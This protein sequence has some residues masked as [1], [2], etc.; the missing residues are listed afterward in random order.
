MPKEEPNRGSV[1][2][3]W[4]FYAVRYAMGTVVG[5]VTFSFL[6]FQ[7]SETQ[8]LLFGIFDTAAAGDTTNGAASHSIS[9]DASRLTLLAVYGLVYCY[10]ASA[11]I[12]V[13]HASRFLIRPGAEW[14]AILKWLGICSIFPILFGVLAFC[15]GAQGK[16]FTCTA[17][18]FG[19]L[20][21]LQIV[22]VSLSLYRN[23]ALFDFYKQLAERRGQAKG[24]IVD[25]Y[26]HLREHGNSFFIVFLE[27]A[28]GIVLFEASRLTPQNT[29]RSVSLPGIVKTYLTVLVVWIFPAVFVWLISIFFERRFADAKV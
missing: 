12:L 23:A 18:A 16:W 28:L 15:Y 7:R 26:R 17:S 11:P 21:G 25:S 19:L 3:W 20:L 2:R 27:I 14:K 8:P 4:E 29:D 10:I 13:F 9:L 1:T 24:E 22:A 6:C 5:A